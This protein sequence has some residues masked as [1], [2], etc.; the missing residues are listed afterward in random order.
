MTEV[1]GHHREIGDRLGRMLIGCHRIQDRKSIQSRHYPQLHGICGRA[2][3]Q[4]IEISRQHA[5]RVFGALACIRLQ[6]AWTVH[7]WKATETHGADD[8]RGARSGRC[9]AKPDSDTLPYETL[10]RLA[11]IYRKGHASLD[12]VQEIELI[13]ICDR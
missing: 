13:D 7:D 3:D 9:L 12:E 1:P 6:I 10:A 2:H 8:K 5:H 4:R 11:R